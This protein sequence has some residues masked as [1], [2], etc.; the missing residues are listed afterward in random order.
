MIDSLTGPK[1][2]MRVFVGWFESYMNTLWDKF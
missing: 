2:I 1:G